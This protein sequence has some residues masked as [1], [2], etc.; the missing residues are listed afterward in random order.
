MK[1]KEKTPAPGEIQVPD[2][3][4]YS[5]E[6]PNELVEFTP[7]SGSTISLDADIYK[8]GGS[9]LKWNWSE[10]RQCLSFKNNNAFKNLTGENADPIVYEWITCTTLSAFGLWIFNEKPLKDV[11][12]FEIGDE[13]QTDSR[14][15]ISLDFSGWASIEFIY[16]RDLTTFPNQKTANTMRILSPEKMNTGTLRFDDFSPRKELDVRLAKKSKVAPWINDINFSVDTSPYEYFEIGDDFDDTRKQNRL[17]INVPNTIDS[18]DVADINR[19]KK[20]FLSRLKAHPLK[21]TV[22]EETMNI[23]RIAAHERAIKRAANGKTVNGVIGHPGDFWDEAN[24]IAVAFTQST[25]KKRR[26]ELCELFIN[27]VD[28]ATQQGHGAWYHLRETFARPLH[29]MKS[30][31]IKCGRWRPVIDRLR[32]IT[33]VTDVLYNSNPTFDAD[34]CNTQLNACLYLILLEDDKMRIYKDLTALRN[35]LEKAAINGELKPDGTLFHHN[36]CYAGYSVPALGPLIDVCS[37]LYGTKFHS[38]TMHLYARRAAYCLHLLSAT[39]T[40]PRTLSGRHANEGTILNW[41]FADIYRKLALMRNPEE[42][43]YFSRPE[44][45]ESVNSK[46][47]NNQTN[48]NNPHSINTADY[49]KAMA[50]IYL[51]FSNVYKKENR[52]TKLF[53]SWGLATHDDAGNLSV[54]YTVANCHR[55]DDWMVFIRGQRFPFASGENYS[56]CGADMC[57]YMNYGYM[58]VVTNGSPANMKESSWINNK[59]NKRGWNFNYF[60]GTTCRELPHDNLRSHFTIEERITSEIFAGGTSLAGNGVFGMKLQ[61]DIPGDKDPRRIGP[62]KYWLGAHEYRKRV[63]HALFDVTFRARKSFF[64]FEDRILCL[65][66]NIES[67]DE[68]ARILTTLFQH[69]ITNKEK[70]A[71]DFPVSTTISTES[72]STWIL[73]KNNTGYYIPKGNAPLEF[74]RA[75]HKFPYHPAW[76]PR[77]PELH[78]KIIKNEG[79]TEF[80]FLNHGRAAA[81]QQYEYCVLIRSNEEKIAK[82][83]D[84]MSNPETALY[85]VLQK[86]RDAHIVR[87]TSSMTTSYVI[88]EPGEVDKRELSFIDRPAMLMIRNTSENT[89]ELSVSTP[90]ISENN[91]FVDVDITLRGDWHTNSPNVSRLSCN[92]GN[93]T[94]T[95]SLIN[96]MSLNLR[97]TK[98]D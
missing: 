65:G 26:S 11:L 21:T 88:F 3:K 67:K 56:G 36:Q 51:S 43:E 47:A 33:G 62:V 64:C 28:L 73:D 59:S 94:I 97:F 38:P 74:Q 27:Y 20:K 24:R 81:D 90:I 72:H 70:R 2:F 9:S 95:A 34:F 55:R 8:T 96:L 37:I 6:S 80:S 66:S 77:K 68:S 16:G 18:K 87:D 85:E 25:S 61:E 22:S 35:W 49:D 91:D 92:N 89:L 69:T 60:P 29:I 1:D 42:T 71:L 40:L 82:F 44:E 7:T 52:W 45:T 5:F 31:L 84:K 83:A 79:N 46:N 48:I 78:N 63:E 13:R 41:K 54:N 17:K 14:F 12:W 76:N 39:V 86:D 30:E 50:E 93:T 19:I 57:R 58:E 15:W 75:F 98:K 4:T 23:I 10:P 53:R 32:D